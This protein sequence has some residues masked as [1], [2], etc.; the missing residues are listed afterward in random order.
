MAHYVDRFAHGDEADHA[1]NQMVENHDDAQSDIADALEQ[2]VE[3]Y[4]KLWEARE[5]ERLMF[6]HDPFDIVRKRAEKLRQ[7]WTADVIQ[8]IV[9]PRPAINSERHARTIDLINRL[10]IEIGC[11][12]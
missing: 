10:A 6:R 8:D 9:S 3:A 4:S 12:P 2:V 7:K 11:T 1:R 5:D